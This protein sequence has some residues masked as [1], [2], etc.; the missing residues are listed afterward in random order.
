MEL[1]DFLLFLAEKDLL[2]KYFKNAE[3]GRDGIYMSQYLQDWQTEDAL[4]G[5]FVWSQSEEGFDFWNEIDKERKD[6]VKK[7]TI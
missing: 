2:S 4:N 1:Y 3:K 6:Y 7:Q 5:A